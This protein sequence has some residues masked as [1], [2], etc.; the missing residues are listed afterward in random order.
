[1]PTHNL[2]TTHFPKNNNLAKQKAEIPQKPIWIRRKPSL[3]QSQATIRGSKPGVNTNEP[4][5]LRPLHQAPTIVTFRVESPESVFGS[6]TSENGHGSGSPESRNGKDSADEAKDKAEKWKDENGQW[7]VGGDK[8][9]IG[10]LR[11]E[12]FGGVWGWE[13][14][15]RRTVSVSVGEEWHFHEFWF[16]GIQRVSERQKDKLTLTNHNAFWVLRDIDE[17]FV[18]EV[19]TKL[20]VI[21]GVVVS[22][23]VSFSVDLDLLPWNYF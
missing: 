22:V 9:R 18:L 11:F 16:A 2:I 1:M 7:E 5:L 10:F 19:N 17:Y 6:A 3:P 20:K 14:R 8:G 23:L 13:R 21:E 4:K 15:R 12:R